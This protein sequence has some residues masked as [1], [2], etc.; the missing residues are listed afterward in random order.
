[1]PLFVCWLPSSCVP[2]S[3]KTGSC[4]ACTEPRAN[5]PE[6]W[7]C[8]QVT[9][10]LARVYS[11]PAWLHWEF[12]CLEMMCYQLAC[13]MPQALHRDS[14]RACAYRYPITW[15][16]ERGISSIKIIDYRASNIF[17][18]ILIVTCLP[19][20]D[21]SYQLGH[22]CYWNER[23]VRVRLWNLFQKQKFCAR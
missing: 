3:M 11:R 6:N 12:G 15:I 1:M 22:L 17:I 4:C 7:S 13:S 8:F 21:A 20:K 16:P 23:K 18:S 2:M 9:T 10:E 14:L 5:S 19:R